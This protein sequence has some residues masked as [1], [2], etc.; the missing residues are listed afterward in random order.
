MK[1]WPIVGLCFSL[2]LCR[3][4]IAMIKQ[5]IAVNYCRQPQNGIKVFRYV[6]HPYLIS[7]IYPFYHPHKAGPVQC[8]F[9]MNT[10]LDGRP[11]LPNTPDK[12]FSLWYFVAEKVFKWPP[13]LKL[14]KIN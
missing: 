8:A 5:I 4:I 11:S 1:N 3:N 9:L 14:E 2:L 13:L 6:A 12:V 7:Q 10:G